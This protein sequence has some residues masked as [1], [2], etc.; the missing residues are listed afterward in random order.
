MYKGVDLMNKIYKAAIYMRLSRDDEADSESGSITNQRELLLNYVSEHDDI[1]LAA[2]FVDDGYTGY[3]FDRPGFKEMMTAAEN[4][5]IDCIIVKDLSRLGRN[6]QKTEEYI[7]RIFPK[8]GIRFL[9][10][11][12]SFDSSR[13]M[14]PI[15]RLAN[16]IMNLMNEYHVMETSQ[17]VRSVLEHY[18]QS[19]KFIGNHAAYGYIIKDKHLEVDEEAAENVRRIFDMK[20]SGLSNQG[21][22]DLLNEEGILSPLE[23]K[24]AKGV[25]ATGKH[26]RDGDRALWQSVSIKRILENPVYIGTLVQGKTTSVS[27]R[28]RRR[29]KRDPAE[30]VTFENAHDAIVSETAFLIVQDLLNK[31]SYTK[32]NKKSYL[33]SGFAYCGNCGNVLYHTQDAKRNSVWV[34]KNKECSCKVRML[35]KPLADAI[36][37]T[38][39]THMDIVVNHSEPV[40]TEDY[41][42]NIRREDLEIVECRKQLDSMKHS[43]ECLKEQVDKGIVSDSDYSEMKCF[44]EDKIAKIQYEI[45][46]MTRNRLHMLNAAEEIKERYRMYFDMTELTRGVVA[47][48]ID[49]IEVISKDKI[50][51]FF[52]YSDLFKTDGE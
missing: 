18:R 16:P 12:N 42:K 36:Y 47:T 22:A 33:F 8:M 9:T 25:G 19:G 13:D 7:Q 21:I 4:G 6:F 2:E 26:L 40:S 15:E 44:Y 51:I 31:D 39:K 50:R 30:L 1:E 17:K 52:R 5:D 46:T 11:T 38:L 45:D 24:L 3:N 29:F 10:V 49:K 27:Y 48:F 35:E 14:S 23:Y 28:D 37:I 43:Q 34:C 20:I 32:G 41:M